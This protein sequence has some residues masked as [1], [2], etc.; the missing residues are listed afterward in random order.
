MVYISVNCMKIFI[1]K[2]FRV[3]NNNFKFW[4]NSIFESGHTHR[5][6]NVF[7]ISFFFAIVDEY[8]SQIV[9]APLPLKGCRI[10]TNARVLW[11]LSREGSLSCYTC[12]DTGPRFSQSQPRK[13][14]PFSRVL[15]AWGFGDSVC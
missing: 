14:D 13:S 12:Y 7:L 9:T 1:M 10:T 11:S 5:R 2:V 4:H 8:F 15:Q 6:D 3:L